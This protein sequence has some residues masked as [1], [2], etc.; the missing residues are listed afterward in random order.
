[1]LVDADLDRFTIVTIYPS[2]QV[3]DEAIDNISALRGEG[4]EEFGAELMDAYAGNML[5][6]TLAG[7]RIEPAVRSELF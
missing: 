2:R 3:R 4:S 5:A 6:S 7:E 1:M